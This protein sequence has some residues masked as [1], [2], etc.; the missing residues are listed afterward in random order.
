MLLG[1]KSIKLI[2]IFRKKSSFV[3]LP[4]RPSECVHI[5]IYVC[6]LY[7]YI[8]VY[9]YNIYLFLSMNNILN[10]QPSFIIV[11]SHLLTTI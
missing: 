8:C 11:C 3:P 6:I 1:S 2:L 10:S 4:L 7:I 5:L 9:G